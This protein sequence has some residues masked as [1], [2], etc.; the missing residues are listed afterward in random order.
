MATRLVLV[1]STVVSNFLAIS[2]LAVPVAVSPTLG[3]SASSRKE[4][5]VLGTS[6]SR[7]AFLDAYGSME[8]LA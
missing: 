4:A 6:S 1:V 5:A 7:Q 8:V 2:G 3:R